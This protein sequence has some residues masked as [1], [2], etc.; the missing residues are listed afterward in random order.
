VRRA[1]ATALL[2][3]DQRVANPWF[4]S[5]GRRLRR[6]NIPAPGGPAVRIPFPPAKSHQR[7]VPAAVGPS[8]RGA[9][10]TCAGRAK[11]VPFDPALEDQPAE[12]GT[13]SGH[14][15]LRHYGS[16]VSLLF[17]LNRQSTKPLTWLLCRAIHAWASASVAN[18]LTVVGYLSGMATS[19]PN[20][21]PFGRDMTR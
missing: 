13:G 4:D 18:S 7:T 14:V 5:V 9:T 1:S 19:T 3:A 2:R 21:P 17:L 16:V 11:G 20:A 8:T 6:R 10:R 15:Q 12:P